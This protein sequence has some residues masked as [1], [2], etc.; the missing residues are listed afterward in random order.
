MD[1]RF[2]MK[3]VQMPE[4]SPES[5]PKKRARGRPRAFKT[6]HDSK[7]VQSLDRALIIL[8]TLAKNDGATLSELAQWA[9]QAPTTTYRALSTFQGHGMV[10]FE[11]EAQIWKIGPGAFR[12]G[13]VFL[14]RTNIL[15][16]TR[17]VMQRLM[18][19]T[20]E[21]ANLGVER[22]DKVMFISQVESPQT[23]RAFFPPG[24][25]NAMHGSGIGKVLLAHFPPERA[26]AILKRQ[27][28]ARLTDQT[29][30]DLPK[31]MDE[32][33]IIREQGF[34][35]DD[36]EATPGMRCVG[37]PVMNA[38]GEPVAGISVSGPAFRMPRERIG[39]VGE[40]V[41]AM[42]AEATRALGGV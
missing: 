26:R 37:A 18:R 4:N 10:D 28:M 1:F 15:A 3:A 23:I 24:T 9:G 2:P 42:A 31:M 5:I 7:T 8:E 30:T 16:A 12:I 20:G 27:G 38:Y 21:T 11:Q 32:L 13:S 17:P 40:C 19:D 6:A 39:E 35:V 36:E 14:N 33:D 41:R 25:L 22:S 29:I 34:G